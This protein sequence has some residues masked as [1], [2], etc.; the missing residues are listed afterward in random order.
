MPIWYAP[1]AIP[2]H[3][4]T[5]LAGSRTYP[6]TSPTG[7]TRCRAQ[8]VH[9]SHRMQSQGPPSCPTS[10]L[11]Y[12]QPKGLPVPPI[13]IIVGKGH[14]KMDPI[15]VQGI[16]D[17][18]TLTNLEELQSF[19]GFENYYKDFIQGYSQITRPLH[20]LTRKNVQWQWNYPQNNAF[21]LLK[22]LFTSYPVLRN[23]DPAKCYILDTDASQYA[24]GA[25]ISQNYPNG[26]HSVAFFSQS[27]SSAK[28]NYNIYNQELLAIIYALKA[29][30]YLLIGAQQKFLI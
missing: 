18:P 20:D 4:N 3:A 26:N 6:S 12:W 10:Q 30:R 2:K 13:T 15:K 7:D 24:V 19:L 21:Q 27:L 5:Y 17:W 1:V 22:E 9:Q 11:T 23:P 29:F 28:C 16:T 14:V 8:S 25:T